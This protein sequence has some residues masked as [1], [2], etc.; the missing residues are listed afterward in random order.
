MVENGNQ[1]AVR[2]AHLR[3]I[4]AH[5]QTDIRQHWADEYR[6]GH[7]ARRQQH[8]RDHDHQSMASFRAPART[9]PMTNSPDWGGMAV[10]ISARRQKTKDTLG[11]ARLLARGQETENTLASARLLARRHLR[12]GADRAANARCV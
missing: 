12:A 9:L 5:R 4:S 2:R 11:S 1:H 7:P 10:N 8:S 3:C 6:E